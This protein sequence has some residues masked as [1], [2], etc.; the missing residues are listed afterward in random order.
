VENSVVV[1]A[2]SP[3]V[4]LR[5]L[6]PPPSPS[7]LVQR[8]RL[9]ERIVSLIERHQILLV[10]AT[11]G[12]GK[13]TA[14]AEAIDQ[15]QRPV[16]WL[17]L[18]ET[19]RA[20][21][22][23]LTYLEAA[24]A[25]AL[26]EFGD[27][28]T[29]ALALGIPHAEAAGLLAEAVAER[30]LVLVLDDLYRLGTSQ[31]PWEVI[32]AFIRWAPPS[33][34]IIAT[35]RHDIPAG[36]CDA[37]SQGPVPCLGEADLAF[38]PPEAAA[39][40]ERA[41]SADIDPAKAVEVTGGW[42][43]GVLFEVWR[44]SEHVVGVG[45][46]AD[47]LHGYL[48]AQIL[49]RLK[50]R[51]RD[52]L[53]STSLLGF[54]TT[55]AAEALGV[56]HAAERLRS[57]RAAHL[58]VTWESAGGMHCHTRFR[59]YLLKRLE[60]RGPAEVKRLRRAY[61]QLLADSGHD[62]EATEEFLAADAD[63]Q[64]L[65]TAEHAIFT[66]IER[67]DIAIATRW[68]EALAHVRRP[69]ADPL[70]TAELM[71]AIARDDYR[72]GVRI[73]DRLQRQHQ[74]DAL[75]AAS[76]RAAALMAWCYLHAM[77][78]ADVDAV[79][80]CAESAPEIDVLRYARLAAESVENH[81]PVPPPATGGPLDAFAF[82]AG[83]Y[84]GRLDELAERP[85]S[86][87]AEVVSAP[88]RVGALQALGRTDEALEL[89]EHLRR[90]GSTSVAF[91]ATIAPDLLI[92]SG[93]REA[94]RAALLHGRKRAETSGSLGFLRQNHVLEAKL[95]LRLDHDPARAVR[96]LAQL[97]CEPAA[98]Q[99]A[100]GAETI[101]LWYGLALLRQ[102]DDQQAL[103]RLRRAVAGMVA[104]GRELQLPTAAVYLAEAE[105]RSED[106]E[107]ADR[108][109]DLAL[110]AARRQGSNH[111]LLQA[112]RDFPAVAS[113]RIDAERHVGSAWHEIGRAL[114]T[115]SE[116]AVAV[117][118]VRLQDFGPPHI[119][120]DG[121]EVKPSLRRA[122]ELLALLCS[123]RGQQL[124]RD[125]L[126]D[127]L[128]DGRI[129][130]SARSYLRQMIQQLD[131]V[132]PEGEKLELRQSGCGIPADSRIS[133]DSA[134]FEM[135][136]G[137]AASQQG[138]ARLDATLDALRV[139][140]RGPF[141]ADVGSA[142]VEERRQALDE[143][144]EAARYEAAEAAYASGHLEDARRLC[145]ASLKSNRYREGA[146]RLRMRIAS[147]LGDDDGVIAAFQQ[148]AESLRELQTTPS[149]GTRQLLDS[150]RR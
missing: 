74:R 125:A 20:P 21:G 106:E 116:S 147:A 4:I 148:C 113:R 29:R 25:Q 60:R 96:I 49:E 69:D 110:D 65:I 142:W 91:D 126:L 132:L 55:A 85:E 141:L 16:A 80:E 5:K 90:T 88:F 1:Q 73:A 31:A 11:A 140:D 87:W 8:P 120:V 76:P 27:P 139:Y 54:V 103:E 94:A 40:L 58:P 45:G 81:Q 48:S 43:T 102:S 35:S 101:D 34:A 37:L 53:I 22:R 135:L 12:A 33:L 64:A 104:G 105:W 38:T 75:A 130:R 14:L 39:A 63:E 41:G 2:P 89:Y 123:R 136:L 18:E 138:K 10:C 78:I 13:T 128:F 77:R 109:A 50:P 19:D 59:E 97:E 134:T 95:A 15:I 56:E 17:T 112:L 23:L 51:D 118:A 42:V 6:A 52:F 46:E 47:P 114:T 129:D 145:D 26:P 28:A 127:A 7:E 86:R 83:H 122:Y 9:S 133:S 24:I 82:V 137:Q 68:L 71:V 111:L 32:Q 44:S 72:A 117:T 84:L 30:P 66:V 61:G 99:I 124:T 36:V 92:D 70:T 57:I 143:L 93:Q 108:A 150:L 149:A 100:H 115:R 98:R 121:T 144:A 3:L 67:L 146:W 119:L 107:A 79:L 131:A 62:E